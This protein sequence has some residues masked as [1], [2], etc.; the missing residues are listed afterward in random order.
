MQDSMKNKAVIN[1]PI[2]CTHFL[3]CQSIPYTTNFDKLTDLVVS[4]GD[5]DIKYFLENAGGM[6]RT[7]LT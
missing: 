4:C 6:Q 1:S 3:A 2:R 5:E 7:H